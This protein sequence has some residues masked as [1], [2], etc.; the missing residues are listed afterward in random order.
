MAAAFNDMTERVEQVLNSQ[1]DF[2]A[3][4][5]HQL[6]TPL[7]GLRLRLE[8]AALKS[9]DPGV[10]RDIEAAER[11][12]ER[13]ARLLNGLLALAREQA[14][15]PAVAPLSLADQVAAAADRWRAPAESNGGRLL[16]EDGEDALV[17]ISPDDLAVIL[18]NLIENAIDYGGPGSDV[19]IEWVRGGELGGAGG[20]RRRARGAAR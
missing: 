11:E 10:R 4:A 12:T 17:R 16:V 15:P 1:R 9:Q 14:D 5:S 7:T 20:Q 2:V 19:T 6:R 18:D 3:N 13:L 8:S